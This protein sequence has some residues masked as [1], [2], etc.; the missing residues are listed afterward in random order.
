MEQKQLKDV[1]TEELK[2]HFDAIEEA[3]RLRE[4]LAA[5]KAKVVDL[6][7]EI[8][9]REAELDVTIEIVH[10][11]FDPHGEIVLGGAIIER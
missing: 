7:Q 3:A 5:M 8:A 11:D 10:S 2:A 4:Q 1:S 9:R 6:A